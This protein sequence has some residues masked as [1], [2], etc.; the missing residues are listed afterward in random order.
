[1]M[2]HIGGGSSMFRLA[3]IVGIIGVVGFFVVA[4]VVAGGV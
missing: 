2:D 4:A 3:L 1:M